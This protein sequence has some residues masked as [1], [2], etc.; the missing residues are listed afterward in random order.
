M[1]WALHFAPPPDHPM[2]GGTLLRAT[3]LRALCI[4]FPTAKQVKWAA[5]ILVKDLAAVVDT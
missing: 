1:A 5:A 3:I 2:A 4:H